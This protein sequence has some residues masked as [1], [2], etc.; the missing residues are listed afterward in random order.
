VWPERD[1]EP[2]PRVDIQTTAIA[3]SVVMTKDRS[4]R[5]IESSKAAVKPT[6]IKYT[7]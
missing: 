7:N 1:C 4:A 3:A 6:I 2:I 5:R